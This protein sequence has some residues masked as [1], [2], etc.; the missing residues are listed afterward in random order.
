[1]K[2]KRL[3]QIYHCSLLF[4]ACFAMTLLLAACQNGNSGAVSNQP[5]AMKVAG[6]KPDT[7]NDVS[8]KPGAHIVF[9][10]MEHDFGK[11]MAGE[12]PETTFKF[13]NTG[14]ATLVIDKV[15]GG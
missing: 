7:S 15:K 14:A 13:K 4:L 9:E 11:V 3:R 1:M 10:S 6:S 5:G 2:L 8:S 12:K